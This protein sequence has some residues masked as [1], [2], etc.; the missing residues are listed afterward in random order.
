MK[1]ENRLPTPEM[2]M[3][4]HTQTQLGAHDDSMARAR[5]ASVIPIVIA[6]LS[7]LIVATSAVVALLARHGSDDA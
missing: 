2:I 7:A 3:A 4:K 5:N 6:L 1:P